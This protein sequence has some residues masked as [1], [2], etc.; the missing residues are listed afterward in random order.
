MAKSYVN[1][2]FI[3]L[4]MYFLCISFFGPI[5]DFSYKSPF[6]LVL[7][8]FNNSNWWHIKSSW[9]ACFLILTTQV[10]FVGQLFCEPGNLNPLNW[11]FHHSLSQWHVGVVLTA[12]R[13]ATLLLILN[14]WKSEEILAICPFLIS[15]PR[16]WLQFWNH[17][18][19][20]MLLWTM[21]NSVGCTDFRLPVFQMSGQH[22][23]KQSK[24]RMVLTF[25]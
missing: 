16:L 21:N 18:P 19:N 22:R 5:W 3:C 11:N 12:P 1:K 7:F 14:N 10:W 2:T 25:L 20:L 4:G 6:Y 24:E 9:K 13:G 15:S 8:C 17:Y 23:Q